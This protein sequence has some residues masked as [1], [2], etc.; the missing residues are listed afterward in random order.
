M[1]LVGDGEVTTAREAY[2]E[3]YTGF[4][5][6]GFAMWE[7][8]FN[9]GQESLTTL[10]RE[11][12]ECL[13]AVGQERKLCELRYSIHRDEKLNEIHN[14]RAAVLSKLTEMLG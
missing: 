12:K 10:L 8:A 9:A 5:P 11:A 14:R 6:A 4:N 1:D 13:E 7:P 2:D 3:K